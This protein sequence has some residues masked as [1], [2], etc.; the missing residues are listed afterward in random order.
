MLHARPRPLKLK[1]TVVIPCAAL[2]ARHLRDTVTAFARQTLPPDEISI[3]ISGSA[4]SQLADDVAALC[5]VAG[6]Q[7]AIV[8]QTDHRVAWAGRNRN[9]AAEH[10]AGDLLIY[11]DA[12]D[13]PHPQRIEILVHL[14]RKYRV[15]HVLHH[16]DQTASVADRGRWSAHRFDVAAAGSTA[17]YER[18]GEQGHAHPFHNGNNATSRDLFREIRWP[19]ALPRGQDV[20]YNRSVGRSRFS[21]AMVRIP[22]PLVTYRQFLSSARARTP[23][24]KSGLL[25]R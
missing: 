4:A 22:W 16:Y 23:P 19:E 25:P 6:P 18:Y 11:Q 1:T 13:L 17:Y 9:R 14:F 10:G 5:R 12:D 20:A 3:C 15:D 21:N 24:Q 7:T 2:H 8:L